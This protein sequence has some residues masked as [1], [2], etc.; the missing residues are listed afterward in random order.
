MTYRM[1]TRTFEVKEVTPDVALLQDLLGFRAGGYLR[2]VILLGGPAGVQQG[3][4][5]GGRGDG[6]ILMALEADSGRFL[7][8]KKMPEYGNIRQ[9]IEYKGVLY[10][11]VNLILSLGGDGLVLRWVGDVDN[12]FEFEV[13]GVSEATPAN[14][15]VHEGR[16]FA[17]TWPSFDTS[18]GEVFARFG[19]MMSPIIP[20]GGLT[21]ADVNGWEEVWNIIDYEPDPVTA[22]AYAGGAVQSWNGQLYWGTINFPLS[23]FR[24]H[25]ET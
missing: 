11:G 14:F 22:N 1:D 23:G 10:T 5:G 20:P 12:P 9:F 18:T 21:P 15:A 17:T 6:I 24:S 25:V 19:L 8:A 3:I 4:A 2:N 16:L 13:V 7:G